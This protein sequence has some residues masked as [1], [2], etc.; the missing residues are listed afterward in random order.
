MDKA[1]IQTGGTDRDDK[2]L[3]GLRNEGL[4]SFECSDCKKPLLVLQLTSIE[5]C[6][7]CTVY[8]KIA[9]KCR[10][11]NSFSPVQSIA[12]RFHP[13][14]PNDDMGFDILDDHSGAPSAEVLFEA[15]SK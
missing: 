6:D 2:T 9:V 8:T 5:G 10:T 15:W 4:V 7:K 1:K 14:A 11:C 3:K 12:G 13:G